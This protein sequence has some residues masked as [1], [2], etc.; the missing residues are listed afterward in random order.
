MKILQGY[1]LVTNGL[2]ILGVL[3]GFRGFVTHFLDEV[4]SQDVV[5]IDDLLLGD[6][7]V[8]LGILSSCVSRQPSYLTW[9]VSLSFMSFLTSFN[10]KIM[11]VCGDIMGPRSGESIQGH[12]VKC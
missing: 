4:L 8:A 5:H 2:G 1:T 3:L 11:Q 12:L 7:Q 6:T 9:T 10:K